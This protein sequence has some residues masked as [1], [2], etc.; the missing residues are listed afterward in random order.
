MDDETKSL[1]KQ[2]GYEHLIASFIGEYERVF[3]RIDSRG[4][5]GRV[6]VCCGSEGIGAKRYT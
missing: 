2:W 5:P 6:S 3:H 4:L 1:L